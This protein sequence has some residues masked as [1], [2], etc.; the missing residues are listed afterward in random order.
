MIRISPKREA[1]AGLDMTPVIDV[2]FILLI[3]FVLAASFT[4]RG[5]EMDLPQAKTTQPLSGRIVE[6]KLLENGQF[7]VDDMP[8]TRADLPYRL[9]ETIKQFRTR[10]GQ[11]VLVA[12]P[13]APCEALI[14]LVDQV[15][16][17]GGENL[18]VAASPTDDKP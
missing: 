17:S 4:V 1:D 15:K 14:H 10:P 6:I 9:Q 16:R 3:F 13:K 7:I 2:V 5:L 11:L 8:T 18:M 12:A